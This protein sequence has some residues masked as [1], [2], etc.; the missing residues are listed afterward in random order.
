M[1]NRVHP[2]APW[3][4]WRTR[5]AAASTLSTPAQ[6][7]S[8]QNSW[9]SSSRSRSTSLMS[10][11]RCKRRQD[12]DESPNSAL[13]GAPGQHDSRTSSVDLHCQSPVPSGHIA[14]VHT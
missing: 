11:Q 2:I 7:C 3:P 14:I 1:F 10:L 5:T 13:R 4:S 9:L 6:V 12:D 8:T